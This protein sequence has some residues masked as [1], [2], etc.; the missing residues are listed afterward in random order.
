MLRQQ[1]RDKLRQ[2]RLYGMLECLESTDPSARELG[3]EERLGLLVDYEWTLRQN[4]CLERLLKQA[5][6]KLNA[7]LEDVDL[8]KPRGLDKTL[9]RSFQGGEWLLEHRNVLITGPTGTGKTY[10]ACALGNW[11][12]RMGFSARYHRLS[13]LLAEVKNSRADGSY[14][15]LT[16]KLAKTHLLLLD[17]FGLEVL[18]PGKSKDLLDIIDDRVHT[19]CTVVTAQLPLEHWYAAIDDAAIAD[20]LMDRLVHG[21]YKIALKGESM[22]KNLEKATQTKAES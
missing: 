14:P 1:T 20:A 12:C 8:G 13:D 3:F 21:S 19:G 6:L 22:R 11:A 2:M 17:D 4:R 7:C 16:S 15:K 5:R 10:L 18:P 9:L